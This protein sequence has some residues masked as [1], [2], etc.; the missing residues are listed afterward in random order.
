MTEY[1]EKVRDDTEQ[2]VGVAIIMKLAK[3]VT[4][5]N[6]LGVNNLIVKL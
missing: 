3:E 5:T 6:T 4:Y 2:D 1:Y